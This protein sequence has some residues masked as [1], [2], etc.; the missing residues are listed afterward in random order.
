MELTQHEA[1]IKAQNEASKNDGAKLPRTHAQQAE[2]LVR[3]HHDLMCKVWKYSKDLYEENKSDKHMVYREC[4]HHAIL[5]VEQKLEVL[6]GLDLCFM[7]KQEKKIT[8][9]TAILNELKQML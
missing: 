6:N 7:D 9:L 5:T 1:E 3:E 4:V 2:A 8:E